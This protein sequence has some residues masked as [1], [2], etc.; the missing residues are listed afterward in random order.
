MHGWH[1]LDECRLD[2]SNY[3]AD[4]N[5]VAAM[6]LITIARTSCTGGPLYRS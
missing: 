5:S 2:L 6:D 1:A 4:L 3:G